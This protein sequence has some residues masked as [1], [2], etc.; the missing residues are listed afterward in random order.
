MIQSV[1]NRILLAWLDGIM[2]TV[3]PAWQI[4]MLQEMPGLFGDGTEPS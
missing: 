2:W 1:Y 3:A 4:E